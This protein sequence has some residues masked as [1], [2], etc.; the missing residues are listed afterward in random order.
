M[1][2]DLRRKSKN[3]KFGYRL[4]LASP[5]EKIYDDRY[6]QWFITPGRHPNPSMVI[7]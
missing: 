1:L 3:G 6:Y 4:E 7:K 5:Q 2:Q